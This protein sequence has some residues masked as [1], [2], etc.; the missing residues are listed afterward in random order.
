MPQSEVLEPTHENKTENNVV[1]HFDAITKIGFNAVNF[2]YKSHVSYLRPITPVNF[3]SLPD[4]YRWQ[5]TSQSDS[6]SIFKSMT[7]VWDI[8]AT[9]LNNC[10]VDY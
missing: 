3:A 1:G 6:S 2:E 9:G 10:S 5:V 7:S 8:R 4:N